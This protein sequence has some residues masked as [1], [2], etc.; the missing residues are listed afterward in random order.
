MSANEAHD[1]GLHL[2]GSRNGTYGLHDA[3]PSSGATAEV[4]VDRVL[5]SISEGFMFC[6]ARVVGV[7]SWLDSDSSGSLFASL[8]VIEEAAASESRETLNRARSKRRT[9]GDGGASESAVNGALAFD[10][11]SCVVCPARSGG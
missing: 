6:A 5:A 1:R 4:A 8:K 11:E 9:S 2:A 7:T 3:S 10:S